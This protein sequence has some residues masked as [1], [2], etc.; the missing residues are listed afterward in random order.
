MSEKLELARVAL[1]QSLA[2]LDGGGFSR[3][4]GTE[5]AKAFAG[6]DL[7]VQPI[8]GENVPVG[9]PQASNY[10]G[11]AGC[12]HCRTGCVIIIESR[13]SCVRCVKPMQGFAVSSDRECATLRHDQCLRLAQ[14]LPRR[15]YANRSFVDTRGSGPRYLLFHYQRKHNV[16]LFGGRPEPSRFTIVGDVLVAQPKGEFSTQLDTNGFGANVGALFRIDAK[17]C[18][19]FAATWGECNTEARHCMSHICR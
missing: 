11:A 1:E 4:V 19:P 17:D 5:E 3:T 12:H 6:G 10:Q 14:S 7:Q 8:H 13:G 18:S 2:D 15:S 9:F 16:A